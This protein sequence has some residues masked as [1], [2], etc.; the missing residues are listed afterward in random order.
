MKTINK[1]STANPILIFSLLVMVLA[2]CSSTKKQA[3]KAKAPEDFAMQVQEDPEFYDKLSARHTR[4]ARGVLLPFAG[5]VVSLAKGAIL[6]FIK[7]EEQRFTKTYR[8]AQTDLFFY[9][10]ISEEHALDPAGM[11]FNGLE[12]VRFRRGAEGKQDTTFFASFSVD[13]SRAFEILNNSIFRLKLDELQV[14]GT[15]LP[16]RRRWY[17]PWTWFDKPT[18]TINLDVSIKVF[19]SWVD[20]AMNMKRHEQMGEFYL[21]LRDVPLKDDP[22]YQ[23]YIAEKEGLQLSGYSY[24]IPRSVSFQ[25]AGNSVHKTYGHGMYSLEVDIT[26]SRKRGAISTTATSVIEKSGALN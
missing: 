7:K 25:K 4:S 17:L 24:L 26:E 12:V 14:R 10:Q 22:R 11:Q 23:Q 1:C 15:E 6:N 5:K 16:A 8:Q 20:E 18:N 2:A 9:N 21:T 19:A 3:E 13:T